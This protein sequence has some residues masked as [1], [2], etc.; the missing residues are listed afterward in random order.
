MDGYCMWPSPY[1][2]HW[3]SVDSGPNRDV[4]GDFIFGIRQNS[5]MKAGVQYSLQEWFNPLYNL[6]KSTNFSTSFYPATKVIP[7][8]K[9]LASYSQNLFFC[10]KITKSFLN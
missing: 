2:Q 7:E 9:D 6:D 1:S 5:G 8:L 10:E 3:N 4:V